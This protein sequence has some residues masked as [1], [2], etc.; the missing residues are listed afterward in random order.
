MYW[1]FLSFF[2]E[3]SLVYI[4]YLKGFLSML[5]TLGRCFKKNEF[6]IR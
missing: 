3:V 4:E 2:L 1:Y 5:E 6:V